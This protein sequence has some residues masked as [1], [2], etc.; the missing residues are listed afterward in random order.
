MKIVGL[1]GG[2]GSGKSTVLKMFQ[3]LGA[4]T[5]SADIEAKKLMN[6]NKNLIAQIIALFGEKAYVNK[7]LNASYIAKIVFVDKKKL[8]DLNALVHPKVRAHFKAY[9]QKSTA[10]IIIY[11]AAILF[12]SGSHTLCD[13]VITV[14]ANLK[15]KIARIAKRDGLLETEI[16]QRMRN[17]LNDDYK[18]KNADF[19]IENTTLKTT[20]S[21]VLT[22]Y[23]SIVKSL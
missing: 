16:L 6:T 17:Q 20:A 18:I 10:K 12:E 9:A 23:N 19:V 7:Q 8:S 11:E 1:T 3:K 2:I 14:T 15:D 22:I 21:Q 13:F 5:Y 4:A